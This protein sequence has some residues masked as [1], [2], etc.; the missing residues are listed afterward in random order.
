MLR[1]SHKPDWVAVFE[2]VTRFRHHSNNWHC[3]G[4]HFESEYE[5]AIFRSIISSSFCL[6]P[7]SP[8]ILVIAG[9]SGS[10]KTTL[11]KLLIERN[12][13]RFV[14]VRRSTTRPKCAKD[15]FETD[16]HRFMSE[17]EFTKNE[18]FMHCITSPYGY[19]YGFEVDPEVRP[20]SGQNKLW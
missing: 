1:N 12:P 7:P 16:M 20:R 5:H 10:G 2:I 8:P 19:R 15:E 3:Y 18:P 9:G 4:Y 13:D 11:T 17:A 6:F 14:W